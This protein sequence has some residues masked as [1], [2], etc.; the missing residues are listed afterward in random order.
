MFIIIDM[1]SSMFIKAV[2]V[3]RAPKARQ[4]NPTCKEDK[5]CMKCRTQLSGNPKKEKWEL[6][7]VVQRRDDV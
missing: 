6:E 7:M 4:E 5:T 2:F 3:L 1:K